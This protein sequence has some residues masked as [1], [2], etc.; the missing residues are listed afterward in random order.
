MAETHARASVNTNTKQQEKK[1][2][3]IWERFKGQ[4][5]RHTHLDIRQADENQTRMTPS[6]SRLRARWSCARN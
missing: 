4:L 3:D 6:W 1:L 5:S 2:G